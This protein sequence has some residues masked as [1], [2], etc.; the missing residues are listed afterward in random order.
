MA[1]D[2]CGSGNTAVTDELCEVTSVLPVA[3]PREAR[4]TPPHLFDEW[5]RIRQRLRSARRIA[6]FL[7]F[8]GTLTPIRNRPGE[9]FLDASTRRC[10]EQLASS[11]GVTISIISGRR[12]SDVER[13][14][15][16]LGIEYLGVHG[17]EGGYGRRPQAS[18]LRLMRRARR[19]LEPSLVG[20]P[21]IWIEDKGPALVVHYRNAG[22]ASVQWARIAVR[23]LIGVFKP[24]LRVICG[25][26]IWEI[27]PRDFPGKSGAV[28]AILASYPAGALPI[29]VGDDMVDEPVFRA[30][31]G[32]ITVRVGRPARTYAQYRLA[33]PDE[34]RQFLT[35]IDEERA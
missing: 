16:V 27:F 5:P 3:D 21:G 13:R 10:L 1:L 30:L 25:K 20:L 6:L 19:Y 8:D 11:P 18:T 2:V 9:V 33:C 29:Y 12:Q 4:R 22:P 28:Q 17:S 26:K 32:G 14:V 31:E 23:A 15:G 35:R 34:V 7:D 24:G